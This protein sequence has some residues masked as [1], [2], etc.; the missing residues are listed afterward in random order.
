[1]PEDNP[2][3]AGNDNDDFKNDENDEDGVD[4]GRKQENCVTAHLKTNL[5]QA[6]VPF[7]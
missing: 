4:N 6:W 7:V 1:M 2:G 3:D 5:L